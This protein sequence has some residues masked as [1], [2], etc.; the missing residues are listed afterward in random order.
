[1][2]TGNYMEPY[3]KART[4]LSVIH[5]IRVLADIH[6]LAHPVRWDIMHNVMDITHVLLEDHYQDLNVQLTSPMGHNVMDIIHVLLEGHYQ[7]PNVRLI[8]PMGLNVIL[9]IHVHLEVQ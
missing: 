5:T 3:V 7:G 4:M 9:I 8:N 6:F 1:M 2:L